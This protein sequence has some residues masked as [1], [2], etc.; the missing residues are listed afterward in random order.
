VV[1]THGA[2]IAFDPAPHTVP[3]DANGVAEF[4]VDLAPAIAVDFSAFTVVAADCSG[5]LCTIIPV[6]NLDIVRYRLV[7]DYDANFNTFT[8]NFIGQTGNNSFLFLTLNSASSNIDVTGSVAFGSVTAQTSATQTVTVTNTGGGDLVLGTLGQPNAPAF[9]L[10]NDNCSGQT[11]TPSSHCTVDVTFS[12]P[13]A[14]DFNGSFDIPSNDP[15]APAVTV[16]VSGTGVALTVPK[17]SVTYA[18]APA[19]SVEVPFGPVT[20]GQTASQTVTVTNAGNAGLDIFQVA[21]TDALDPPFYV[22]SDNC[23][24]TTL[25]PQD[26]CV[27]DIDF[28]PTAAGT[29]P[30]SLDIP[31]NDP[32]TSVV[33]V[34]V[35]GT[36]T[37][38]FFPDISVDATVVSFNNVNKGTSAD[39][40]ITVTNVGTA[41]LLIGTVALTNLNPDSLNPPPAGFSI[42]TDNC[43]NQ[44]IPPTASC[45]IGVTFAPDAV[46]LY[47]STVDIPTSNDPDEPMVT[48]QVSGDGGTPEVEPSAQG[49]SSGF[50]ALDPATLLV[51]GLFAR[52]SR[53]RRHALR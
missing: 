26:S 48:V 16:L 15:D 19:G 24:N 27:F 40:T 28:R 38:E 53:R 23:S 33:T 29:F 2:G 37:S 32:D 41:D 46:L 42:A 36:G 7:I 6:L 5:P 43:S 49:A 51:L 31:S 50:M 34:D 3:L 17:I 8:A 35:S 14:G 20:A 47:A 13:S 25:A 39:K 21:A 52:A 22:A 1:N 44:S 45:T 10:S 11:V 30:D 12:P 4:L 18:V 9:A